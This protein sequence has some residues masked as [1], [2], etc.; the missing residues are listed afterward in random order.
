MPLGGWRMKLLLVEPLI[1][2]RIFVKL[3]KLY[4]AKAPT[5]QP[6]DHI[7]YKNLEE[8]HTNPLIVVYLHL[9]RDV[10]AR[11]NCFLIKFQT[12]GPMIPF[13]GEEIIGILRWLMGF[14]IRKEV[15]KTADSTYKLSKLQVS[16]ESN[17]R[18]K[19]DIKPTTSGAE[20]LKK[21]PS[22]LR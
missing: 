13:L 12:D 17:W 2:V 3:I 10:A 8:Y 11:L 15:L 6:K 9:F 14:F 21:V 7:S 20:A 16:D 1:S 5:K 19:T 4:V 22:H 18:L